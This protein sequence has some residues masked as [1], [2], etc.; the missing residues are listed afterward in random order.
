[1]KITPPS[2]GLLSAA[3]I[4]LLLPHLAFSQDAIPLEKAREGAR[5]LSQTAGTIQDAGGS[6]DAD[7]EK[8]FAI[9][10]HNSV[11]FLVVPDKALTA[12]KLDSVG[13]TITPIAQLWTTSEATVSVNGRAASN[14]TLRFYT[15]K[16]S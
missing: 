15:L 12:T 7:L 13:A 5:M 2:V 10:V 9:K 11:G 4:S 1:M 8:P 3:F 16:T 6:V 14:S